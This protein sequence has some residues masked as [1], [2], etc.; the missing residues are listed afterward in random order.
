MPRLRWYLSPLYCMDLEV[1]ESAPP[2]K[3]CLLTARILIAI[4]KSGFTFKFL[5]GV[6]VFTCN[7]ILSEV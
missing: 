2:L 1:L 4:D 5:D 6:Y 7:L 3:V